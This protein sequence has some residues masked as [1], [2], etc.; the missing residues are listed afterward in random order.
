MESNKAIVRFINKSVFKNINLNFRA[1][2]LVGLIGNNGVGKS[3]L[4]KTITGNLRP[5]NGDV[6]IDKKSIQQI[7]A[8][9]LAQQISRKK[10]KAMIGKEVKVIVEAAGAAIDSI[11]RI[12]GLDQELRELTG[13]D[14]DVEDDAR[15]DEIAQRLVKRVARGSIGRAEAPPAAGVV[16]APV[17]A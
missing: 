16:V 8:Q 14:T 7:S 13:A 5:I 3:T 1:G 6:L 12:R 11:R 4:L 9:E 15:A 2:E 17:G 10:C